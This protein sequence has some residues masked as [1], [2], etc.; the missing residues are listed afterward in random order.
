ML[1]RYNIIAVAM[2]CFLPLRGLSAELVKTFADGRVEVNWS[3][4]KI[5][6]YGESQV[7]ADAVSYQEAEK[8][9]WQ[10]GLDYINEVMPEIRSSFGI[11]LSSD[12]EAVAAQNTLVSRSSYSVDTRY[13]NDGKIRVYLES[14]LGRALQSPI[15]KLSAKPEKFEAKNS[16]L[17]IK[18]DG[19][20]V[21]ETYKIINQNNDIL[22]STEDVSKQAFLRN[23]MGRWFVKDKGRAFSR[24][25]GP[26]PVAV[27]GV[28]VKKGLIRVD[29]SEWKSSLEG[30]QGLL[31]GAKV[32]LVLKPAVQ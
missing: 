11:S 25:V 26:D 14:S 30:N 31:H 22:F 9:A 15:L 8:R 18:L 20:V 5:K 21:S 28:L 12:P 4:M 24:S 1:H 32:A 3:S 23:M 6:Y 7:E 29:D 13:F 10:N 2:L 27:G 16:G 17:I 19:G